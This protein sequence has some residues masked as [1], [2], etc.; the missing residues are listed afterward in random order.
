MYHLSLTD[1]LHYTHSR[2]S[3]QV[4][5]LKFSTMNKY[6][7][8]AP[9]WSNAEERKAEQRY[10]SQYQDGRLYI[11]A[12]N[13]YMLTRFDNPYRRDD[14]AQAWAAEPGFTRNS[15]ECKRR[16]Y[17][18]QTERWET[19]VYHHYRVI[20]FLNY[21]DGELTGMTLYRLDGKRFGEFFA[22]GEESIELDAEGNQIEIVDALPGALDVDKEAFWRGFDYQHAHGGLSKE[23]A[24][25]ARQKRQQ[26][27]KREDTNND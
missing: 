21:E 6:Q 27:Q 9:Y 5:T 8:G 11:N 3:C 17:W 16:L 20:V 22:K 18:L 7:F 24:E 25:A 13:G 23:Q 10:L 12:P 1:A 15:L 2:A 19:G 14:L 4:L 26:Q